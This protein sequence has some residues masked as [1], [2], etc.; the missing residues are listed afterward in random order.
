MRGRAATVA[1]AAA[2]L[3]A[4]CS[5]ADR[6]SAATTTSSRSASTTA[7]SAPEAFEAT[8]EPVTEAQ[9]SASWRPGCPL[10]VADL[11]RLRVRHW[12]FDDRVHDGELIVGEGV[13]DDLV[14]VLHALFDARY[15]IEKIEPIDRYG[16][17]DLVSTQANNTS[18]FNCRR[19]TG[20]TG[21]SLHAYGRAIDLNPLQ[22]PYVRGDEVLPPEAVPYLDRTRTDVGLVHEDDA[23]V[24]AFASIG[25]TWGGHWSTLKDYQH[26]SL[27]SG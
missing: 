14:T 27:P 25:W 15:P 1:I 18:A 8:V 7:T 13:A 5:R 6:P 11:R 26:F 3:L 4:S 17:D 22:N 21:W 24:R 10:P 16:G 20:G 23:A 9:L 2:V 19:A 12:G